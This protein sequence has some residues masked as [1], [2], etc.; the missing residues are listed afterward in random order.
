MNNSTVL[1]GK[2]AE[3]ASRVLDKIPDHVKT[4][5]AG[6][7]EKLTDLG[8][9]YYDQR[10]DYTSS[11]TDQVISH[12]DKIA[13]CAQTQ[14]A[15]LGH[16]I[17]MWMHELPFDE[18]ILIFSFLMVAAVGV[19][20]AGAKAGVTR[21]A[22]SRDPD[23]K[24]ELFHICDLQETQTESVGNSEALFMPVL[25]GVFLC[26][27]YFAIKHLSKETVQ[28]FLT[29][30]LGFAGSMSVGMV[31]SMA[32]KGFLRTVFNTHVAHYKIILCADRDYRGVGSFSRS[33]IEQMECEKADKAD[34]KKKS[35]KSKKKA[36]KGGK[37][38]AVVPVVESVK[39]TPTKGKKGNKKDKI[40]KIEKSEKIESEETVSSSSNLM[41]KY[42]PL[43]TTEDQKYAVHFTVVDILCF[44]LSIFC[45]LSMI[46]YPE[47]AQNW[48]VNN[49]LGVCMAITGMSTLK[50]STF[51]SGLIM[52]AGLF[53]YDI[54]FVFGTD[55]MLTVATSIDGPIKLVV[56]KN[57]FGKG[58]LLGL[59]D[60]VVPG[61]YMSLCLRYDVF[62]YYKDGK[63]PF[64]LAR[65]I[66]APYFVSSLIF[67]VI[68]LITTM[69]VLFV[70][71]HG[72]PALLYIC[73]ALMLST[74]LV[75]VYQGELGALWA[76]DGE[77]E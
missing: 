11:V 24:S 3:I 28:W 34:D 15:Q 40:E 6:H 19:V 1:Q 59:G 70:F 49:I 39:T 66:N 63:Q 47:I 31:A 32:Y 16:L 35:K 18:Q 5:V 36:K 46:K 26:G 48:I 75:G 77:K 4:Q 55:I 74:L 71:E 13:T 54:F 30:Y 68:A 8:K 73:P 50:L 76:Y 27:M 42:F 37:A 53:F 60:M 21:P 57:E 65:K 38:D 56:P 52:L 45:L 12:Y 7:V 69:V 22:G 41:A 72:Q 14:Y 51:S 17:T 58:A 2:V 44:F 43:I 9:F 61:V 62:R 64:H 25:G 29:H 10:A 33:D 67:Y 20:Y 23:E